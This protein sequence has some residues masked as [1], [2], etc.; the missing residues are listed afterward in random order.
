MVE[1]FENRDEAYQYWRDQHTNGFVLNAR[2]SR[3]TDY[4]VLHRVG[5]RHISVY[6]SELHSN[7]F[8][9]N[10]YIKICSPR[11]DDLIQWV[12]D[13]RP[14][15]H[16]VDRCMDCLGLTSRRSSDP[17]RF[18]LGADYD[19][20]T[21]IHAPFGGSA[22]SGISPSS[23]F[24]VIFLFTGETGDQ[25]GYRDG[26]T[27][28]GTF[29]YTGEGQVGDMQLVRGN[30]AIYEHAANGKT[31]HLF[32]AL[33][34]PRKQRYL[35]E[36]TLI[37]AHTDRTGP[38]RNGVVRKLIV[39]ELQAG[40]S[41]DGPAGFYPTS[42]EVAP[43]TSL[44]E[45]RDLAIAAFEAQ[46]GKGVKSTIHTQY[47]RS[48]IIRSYV[49]RR[50]NGICES[51]NCPAPFKRL[52]GS[53]YLEVHHVHRLSD[54]GIDHPNNTAALCPSCHREVHFGQEKAAITKKLV[55]NIALKEKTMKVRATPFVFDA[56]D[57]AAADSNQAHPLK[58]I[59]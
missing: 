15:V 39:F 33:I 55:L 36:H 11:E 20:R 25:Y 5:C 37:R 31:L 2:S 32:E 17:P 7:A 14:V 1:V 40:N 43:D 45:A 30:K 35:G 28:A 13:H 42:S 4:A 21:D 9:G 54:G 27:P 16:K 6:Q 29:L 23:A 49:L 51:C 53:P 12:G 47:Q 19:R 10:G 59:A 44:Q 38:D 34:S 22:Q 8:T 3:N 57:V 52:D 24:P 46:R 18:V 50:A 58:R 56:A 48:E 26:P 41:S